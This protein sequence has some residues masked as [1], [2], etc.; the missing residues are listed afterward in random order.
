MTDILSIVTP[1]VALGG[2]GAV[3]GAGL[4]YASQKFA[5]EKDPKVEQ[6][7]AVLP[8]A[9]C[10]GC[11]FPGCAGLAENIVKGRAPVNAC[12][13]GGAAVAAKVAEIMGVESNAEGERKVAVV[14]CN[15]GDCVPK[16]RYE[17]IQTCR[18]AA[19]VS[20]GAKSCAYGCL[21]LGDCAVV[22]PFGAITMSEKNIPIIDYDKCTGCGLC[23]KQCPKK[24]IELVRNTR[25]VHVHCRSVDKGAVTRKI[26]S[27]GCIG[28]G[29]CEKACPFDAIHVQNNLAIIDYDKCRNC[30]LC[31]K[32]CPTKA[33]QIRDPEVKLRAE[34]GEGCIGCT[35]CAKNCP[36][37]AISG[38]LK[39]PHVVDKEKCVG[40]NVCVEKC[41]KKV[42]SLK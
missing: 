3:L 30:G 33:I 15:G 40:C 7:I 41:P 29:L 5:V 32:K 1:V 10:G 13:V 26:C 31:E 36:T 20:G 17:G 14:H 38:E 9:N 24:V 4:A 34:I 6:I 42:I 39:Q 2:L 25:R 12:P 8:G 18:A 19:L 28:C 27:V 37:Q 23:V 35:I 21:G 16:F 22:C 11:G